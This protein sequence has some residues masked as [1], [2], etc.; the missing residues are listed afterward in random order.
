LLSAVGPKQD[1]HCTP[2]S[3]NVNKFLKIYLKVFKTYLNRLSIKL[4]N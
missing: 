2:P 1:A 3:F 4:D